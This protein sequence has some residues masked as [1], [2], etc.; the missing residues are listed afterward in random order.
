MDSP[1]MGS[2]GPG[3]DGATSPDTEPLIKDPRPKELSAISH[4][5][6]QGYKWVCWKVWLCHIGAVCSLGLLLVLFNWRPRLGILARCKSCPISMAD[7]LLLKDRYGQEFVVDVL[8]EEIE[9]GSLEF[10][11]G[12][13]DENECRDTVQL[14]SEKKTL[15]RYYV[16]EGMRYIWIARKGAFCKA[17]ILNE[18]WTCADLHGRQQG[19]SKADQST[20]KQIFG[21]NII[22]VP[23]KS[24]L[25]LLFE[26]VLNPFYIFQVFSVILWMSDRYYYY[27]AC[28]LIISLISIGVS[29][30]EIRKQST[31]LHRMARLVVNVTVRR[32]TGEEECV[33]SEELVPGDCIVIPAEGLLLP[34][35]AA[36]LAGEC[37]VNES[38]L[39]GESIPVMKTP[40]SVSEATYSPESQRRHTLFCGTQL[41]QAK[42]GGSAR[43][44]AIAVAT[45]TG[46]F[47]AKGD[48]IS[49]ILYPQPLDFRFYKD[50]MK[51]LLFLGLVALVGTIYSIVILSK[52][53]TT[54]QELVIRSLDIVTIIVP[55]ALPAAIT[56]ATIYAQNRLKRH[57]VFCI[58]PPR[59]NICG[60]TSLFCFDKTGTLTEDGLDVWGV[61]EVSGAVFSELVP[62]P[63][64]LPPGRMLS[65]LASC[66][67]LALLGGQALGDPLELKMIESTGWELTEPENEMGLDS[68]FGKHRVLAVMR[69]PASELLSPGNSVSQ[70]VAIIRRFPFSSSLQRMSVVT[71][72]PGGASPV[73]FLK[74]APEMV[75]SFCL[76]ESV[77]SHFSPILREYASQG[78]RVLGF[79]YKHL[80]KETDLST[81]E[82][83][84]VEKDM[85]FL[86]L[87]VM[88]NQVKPESAEVIRTLK[89][90]Q[91]R[92]VMITGD[93]ILTAVNVARACGMVL[94]HEK[95]IFV[96]ASPPTASSMASLQFHQGDGAVA[97]INTQETIDIPAQ[98]LYQNGASYH[99]AVNGMSFAALC[100]HFP[101]YLPKILLRGTVYARMTP[102]Q[103]TQLV[104]ALQ[105]LN[106][107]VGMCGDGANDCG[108]LRAADVGVSLSEAEAS[109][110]SPFTSKSNNISCVPLLIKEGRC[111]LVTSFSLFK[112]MALYSLIQFA[113]VLILY[114]EKTNLGD[115][116][117]LFFDLVL[118]TVLAIVMGRGGPSDELHPQRPAASLL[119]LPVL[120]SL[121]LHTVL[122]ILAQV[123]ALLITVSQDWYVPLNSTVTGAANLPNMEDTSIFALSGFQYIIMSI[124]ITK[125][126]PYKKPLYY[127]FLFVGALLVFFALMSW[128]VLFRHTIIHQLL[129]LY[130]INDM[131]YKLLLVA[132]AALNFFICYMLEI[133]IDRGALNCLRNLRG[134]RKSKK[135]YKRLNVQLAETPSWPPLNQP[136]FPTQCSVIGVS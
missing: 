35:D 10:A 95:V 22:D 101:E 78:F 5:D 60:K 32:D 56:T 122:L 98:G 113:S 63:L 67:T 4:M 59:I 92:P 31:T 129:Q 55:P 127:N 14:H 25:Q 74:G 1:G 21:A 73:T 16:F 49:S 44:G 132:V 61:M 116:Q 69:P 68:E 34:C 58:S 45:H 18:G 134:K 53:N 93:N 87:L 66:H 42:G 17:S 11:V 70:P 52:S 124:V 135:Q 111:S 6:V 20:R 104:K 64:F 115:L 81:V 24:Y 108:A 47:T 90:A 27:A 82:R 26:E 7:V 117:F 114:T 86:G 29:L 3:L 2:C 12:E 54:W 120:S 51:F 102:E 75:A 126:Y 62:D 40:L 43:N 91:L 23:V 110:A 36:L 8:T 112:Y 28:I 103:K 118:V 80:T 121:L 136:L 99:L 105:K 13:A 96:H 19:L 100:D 9:E 123:S 33:S 130:D 65:A 107:R 128:L 39:T 83:V 38:M 57:G 46:F 76:R 84:E 133:L 94:S 71:V 106:Y 89:L 72:G 15:L 109:V 119:S 88:K 97:T 41:I 85:N 48:L 37:M 30:Y 77:P 125:G 50:A 79:A 131:N